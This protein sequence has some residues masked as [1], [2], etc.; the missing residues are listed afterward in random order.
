MQEM[1]EAAKKE[2]ILNIWSNT[3]REENI[4][5]LQDAFNQRFGLTTELRRVNLSAADFTTRVITERGR[6][7]ADFGQGEAVN[8]ISLMESNLLEDFDW[9]GVFGETF[10]KIKDRVERVA[11][12][13]QPKVLDYWHLAYV[14]AY[15]TDR[16]SKAELPKTWNDLADPRFRGLMA[17]DPRGYPFNFFA[18]VWG[19]DRVLALGRAV[20]ANQPV[21]QR[22]SPAIVASIVSGETVLGSTSSIGDVDDAKAKGVPVDWFTM[23][24]IPIGIEHA[25]VPKGAPHV[26][27]ARLWT[28]WITTEGRPLFEQLDGS[29]LA[30][31]DE[32]SF[33]AKRL[34]E[35][36]T[37]F[38]FVSTKEEADLT[39]EAL[40]KLAEIYLTR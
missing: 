20:T 25:I 39:G 35:N 24:E 14:T 28:A 27:T 2:N 32:E 36:N 15:R 10:P 4:K 9:I 1:I 22:G 16:L 11:K 37:K 38:S 31:P 21:F 6:A 12:P 40:Q 3:P 7:E 26:N 30:W 18:P 23:D 29:G 17:L 8:V 13:F 33:L 19:M 34:K 5:A